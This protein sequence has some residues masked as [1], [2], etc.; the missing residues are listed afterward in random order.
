MASTVSDRRGNARTSSSDG[1]RDSNASQWKANGRGSPVKS[2][3]IITEHIDVG[4]PADDAFQ[5]W[6]DY[7][8]WSEVFKKESAEPVKDRSARRSQSPPRV[9]AIAKIGPSERRWT[10]EVTST[11]PGHQVRWQSKG[12][13]QARGA[14]TFH[15]L[16]DRLT[17]VMVEIEYRPTGLV[18]I[19]GNFFR[20]QRRRVRRDLRLF[21]NYLELETSLGE[22]RER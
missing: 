4:V 19:I 21:K 16:G 6:T 1:D 5:C 12:P 3:H 9:N 20:M 22:G 11:R 14:T 7:E 10:A 18:E 2:S 13:V 15:R 8:K 17:R